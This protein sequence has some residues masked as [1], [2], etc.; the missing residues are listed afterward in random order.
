LPQHVN[1]SSLL[2]FVAFLCVHG[3]QSHGGALAADRVI[4]WVVQLFIWLPTLLSSI[5]CW[6]LWGQ[7]P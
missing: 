7:W 2:N 6:Q 1:N 3:K 4:L 5:M